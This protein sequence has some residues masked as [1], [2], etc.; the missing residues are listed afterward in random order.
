MF[1]LAGYFS[2]YSARHWFIKLSSFWKSLY[3][4]EI[5]SQRNLTTVIKS[6]LSLTTCWGSSHVER[7]YITTLKIT[8]ADDM[9]KLLPSNIYNMFPIFPS[10]LV[11]IYA[12]SL[13][14]YIMHYLYIT[15]AKFVVVSRTQVHLKLFRVSLIKHVLYQK[16]KT[17][18]TVN[19][20]KVTLCS[21]INVGILLLTVKLRRKFSWRIVYN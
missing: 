21:N 14:I 15:C 12:Q 3:L 17:V 18:T 1:S 2:S 5:F 19:G 10:N 8:F 16:Y 20:I 6:H 11:E 9:N 7:K 13:D 4:N